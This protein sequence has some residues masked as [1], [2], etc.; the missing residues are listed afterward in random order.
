MRNGREPNRVGE[1][2]P[3]DSGRLIREPSDLDV[4]SGSNPCLIARNGESAKLLA[5]IN[6]RLPASQSALD[7]MALR[8]TRRAGPATPHHNRN[9]M[10]Q[11]DLSAARNNG[12]GQ[13]RRALVAARSWVV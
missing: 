2:S 4:R 8:T 3:A 9:G 1:L 6:V 12:S 5:A 7:S 10:L 11:A 13:P